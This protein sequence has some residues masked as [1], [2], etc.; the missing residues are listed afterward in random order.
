[1]LSEW[2]T[3][4]LSVLVLVLMTGMGA[5]LTLESFKMIARRPA[6]VLIGL[7]SQFG[8]M[9]LIA[10]GLTKL[11]GLPNE[12]AISLIIV[13]VSP[14]GTTS[15][16]F[17]YFSRAD[18]ALSL[19]MTAIS[20]VVAIVMM[21]LLLF[22]YGSPFTDA[23]IGIPYGEVVKTLALILIPVAVGMAI[24]QKSVWAAKIIERV[25]AIAGVS[26]LLLLVANGFIN[27]H[28]L[29][30]NSS[31]SLYLSAIGLGVV[32]MAAGY[33]TARL[34]RL[35]PPARRAVTLETGIQNS[36]LAIAVIVLAFPGAQHPRMLWIPLLYALFVLCSSS[37]VTLTW[38]YLFP[39]SAPGR[40]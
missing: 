38:R 12:L 33:V 31:P 1:M 30:L 20:T 36:P 14:G 28:E 24:R 19:S 21:P 6:G 22:V 3:A 29:I 32:G 26:V 16:M 7:C 35:E 39:V 18:L 2:E 13:G 4:L 10:F 5:T 17:T 8:W 9:P 27:H 40:T 37:L 23:S 34:L 15:N 25:G 11:A